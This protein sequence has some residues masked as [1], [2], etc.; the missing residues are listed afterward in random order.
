MITHVPFV[1][2]IGSMVFALN[3]IC[4]LVVTDVRHNYDNTIH[5]QSSGTIIF[6]QLHLFIK[7]TAKVYLSVCR[8]EH[9]MLKDI[10]AA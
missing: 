3:V 2:V 8:N 10:A 5:W 1:K 7:M 6:Q 4:F 9:S